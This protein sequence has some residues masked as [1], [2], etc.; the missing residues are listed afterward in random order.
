MPWATVGSPPWP[1]NKVADALSRIETRLDPDTVTEL[2]NHVKAGAPARADTDDIRIIEEEERA[3]QEVILRTVQLARQDKKFRNLRTEN[4]CQA[5]LMDPVIPHVLDW[6]RLPRNNRVK[7]KSLRE[8]DFEKRD[9]L[10]FINKTPPGN[11]G[12]IP[13][14]VVPVNRRQVAIDMCHWNAGHQGRDRTLS[15]MKGWFWWPGMATALCLA[16]QNCGRCKQ[17]EA[18]SQLPEMEPIVC[19]Q[20]MELVH[21]DYVG[22]EVTVAAKEKPVVKNVLVVVDHFTHYVQ[23][24]VM[25]NHTARTTARVLYNNFFS[26]FSFPQKLL[27]DQGTEFTGDV[28]ATMCKLLG[29]EKIRT[30]PYHSQTN[31]LAER[32]HQTLQ[33]MIGKLDPEKHRKW[34][35]HIGSVLI[36][37][38]ATQ[39]QVT[40]YSPYFL[41]FGRRPRLPV[42]LLFP[43]V[44]NREWTHTIDEYVKA[45]YERLRECLKLAQESATKE[46]NRQKRLYDRR[47]GAVELRPGDRV[48]VCLDA[49]RGQR[50]KLKNRW[51]DDIHTMID[52]KADGIPV[53]EVK[54]ERTGKKQVLHQAWLLLWLADYG[55]P[56]RYN[57]IMIGDTLP[58]TVPGQQLDDSGEGLHPVPGESLQYGL[59][60]THFMAIIDN[61]EL[62]TSHIRR[63]VRTGIP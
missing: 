27:S 35:E 4:W 2:L 38:N 24:F 45:L 23:A 5:Q 43:T 63:E 44:N 56:V 9:H 12:T 52:C 29:I 61:P 34:P 60:L 20:P 15:L 11:V 32:V 55:E 30:T 50:R 21:V 33:R 58:G 53:Y 46:A 22:M 48:L 54:N 51:G 10:L 42:D 6:L 18:K 41:M 26:V 40:G 14:F 25:K 1:A 3:D 49:F 19:T 57:L 31:G 16:I 28:I 39:S 8:K 7:G 13:V 17:F 47:V 36:A 59:D 37:Y 62:M